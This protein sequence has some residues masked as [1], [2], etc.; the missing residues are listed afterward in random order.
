MFILMQ[1]FTFLLT[2]ILNCQFL[3]KFVKDAFPSPSDIGGDEFHE[4][5]K[6]VF[7]NTAWRAVGCTAKPPKAPETMAAI[8]KKSLATEPGKM[9]YNFMPGQSLS[10]NLISSK[11]SKAEAN[12]AKSADSSGANSVDIWESSEEE[13]EASFDPLIE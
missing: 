12:H 1:F 2:Y 11:S 3:L 5:E 8:L 13:C 10:N 6:P 9:H 4:E 7:R